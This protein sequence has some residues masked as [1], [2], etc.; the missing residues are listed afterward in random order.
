MVLRDHGCGEKIDGLYAN[1][2]W[3]RAEDMAPGMTIKPGP[4]PTV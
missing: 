3:L 1:S 4:D 2:Y